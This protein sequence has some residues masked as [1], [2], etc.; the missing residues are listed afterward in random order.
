MART[1]TDPTYPLY[2]VLSIVCSA[3]LLLVLTTTV[4]RLKW[5]IGVSMLCAGL[6]LETLLVGVNTIVW[7]ESAEVKATW[8]CDIYSHFSIWMNV[9][10]PACTFVITRRLYQIAARRS[11]EE[12]SKAQRRWDL[13][14]EIGAVVVLPAVVTGALYYVVQSARFGLIEGFGPTNA[15]SSDI[16]QILLLESWAIGFS[17]ISVLFYCPRILW[18]FYRFKRDTGRYLSDNASADSISY[19]R[20]LCLGLLDALITFPIAVANI[21][22]QVKANIEIFGFIPFYYGWSTVHEPGWSQPII[23]TKENF[24]AEPGSNIALS[25][26]SLWSSVVLGYAIF[27][28]FGLTLEARTSYL[29]GLGSMARTFG[30]RRSSSGTAERQGHLSTLVFGSLPGAVDPETPFSTDD[31]SPASQGFASR[32]PE[33]KQGLLIEKEPTLV[34]DGRRP[35]V[36]AFV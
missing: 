7:A 8:Y 27:F 10:K 17:L 33:M 13:I 2:P 4:V 21:T 23:I 15:P 14:V 22:L 25:Y 9:L 30:I 36:E 18:V 35:S 1:T 12:T 28:L 29:H 20:I 31:D 16:L 5:N 32:L 3:C 11:V 24:L 26:V 34:V 19:T 6:F